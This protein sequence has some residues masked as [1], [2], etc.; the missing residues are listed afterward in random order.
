MY[1]LPSTA[2][3]SE[4]ADSIFENGKIITMAQGTA[5][6][7]AVR[8]GRFLAVGTNESVARLIGPKTRRV[9]LKGATVI[10]GLSDSHDHLWNT[11]KYLFR[12]VDMVGVDSLAELQRRLR[13]QIL[14]VGADA[15]VFT[16]TGWSVK[17]APTRHDLDEVSRTNPI[18]LIARRRGGGLLNTPALAALG[19]S[20]DS[21]F[22]RG[23]Q[24]PVD[25]TGEP[26]GAP[27]PYP[28]SVFMIDALL[29]PIS[30]GQ[31]QDMVAHAMQERNALGITSIRE[32]AIWPEGVSVLQQMRR[33]EA[34]TVRMALGLEFP[35]PQN[36]AVHLA[37]ATIDRTDPWLFLDCNSEEPWAAGSTS[38]QEF[39]ALVEKENRM[40][41]RPAP[42]VSADVTRRISYDDVTETTLDA[43]SSADSQS[44][45]RGKR[46]Y[47]EHVPF[48]T[49]L[50]IA[51][52]RS[53]GLIVST[54][55]LGFRPMM[56]QLPPDRL[57][58]VNPIRDFVN[59]KLT[60]IAGSDYAGPSPTE[61]RPNNPMIPFYFYTT[62]RDQDGVEQGARQK[63]SRMQALRMLTVNAAF[64]TFQEKI[65][66]RIAPDMLADFVVLNQ[67]ILTV[68]D[69]QLLQ[70][71]PI[72]TF[73]GGRQVYAAPN[74]S[75]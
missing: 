36:T 68:P 5:H 35:D 23:A 31:A 37:A 13:D 7:F 18:V 22:F 56:I 42:H 59:H 8:N 73:V 75:F 33:K 20:K 6:A 32:L 51:R 14:K 64:A 41:W 61:Q 66:G 11:E 1:T 27:P 19:I 9:D 71:H 12:G 25:A 63:V 28:L 60:V 45:L 54:Q 17:P 53:L 44:A 69:S 55:D 50:Q 74:S 47:M 40:G 67:D 65:K 21:P 34:L 4:P 2:A 48:A 52:M 30:E 38:K 43:Y 62:R 39:T 49:Q 26:T 57:E 70:T 16:T 46:W 58:R 72:A 29:P 3:G 24:V 15:V 10:P